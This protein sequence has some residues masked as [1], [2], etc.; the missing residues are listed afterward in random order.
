MLARTD[1]SPK[2][3]QVRRS[4]NRSPPLSGAAGSAR[5]L[6][7][8]GSAADVAAF[9]FI[10]FIFCLLLF[11]SPPPLAPPSPAPASLPPALPPALA[12]AL[13]PAPGRDSRSHRPF[14]GGSR[15]ACPSVATIGRRGPVNPAL[16]PRGWPAPPPPLSRGSPLPPQ[17][18]I[19]RIVT[20]SPACQPTARRPRGRR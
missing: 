3:E 12:P 8:V 20:A 10:Y 13:P 9:Y 16:P 6:R 11:L 5:H 18:R 1:R 2:S 15:P 4:Q 19:P 7:S 17:P 14:N